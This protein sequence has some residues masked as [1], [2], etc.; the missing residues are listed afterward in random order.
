MPKLKYKVETPY[1]ET[2]RSAKVAGMF[3][4]S[5]QKKLIKEWEFDFPIETVKKDWNIGLIVGISG[6]G[7]SILAKKIFGEKNYHSGFEW[8]NSKSFLDSF[9]ES[10]GIK[11]ITDALSHIGFSSPP[12]WLLPFEKLSTGQKFRAEMARCLFEY[13][14]LFVFDEFTSVVDRNVAKTGSVAIQKYIRALNR[15]VVLVSCHYDIMEWLQPD[16]CFDFST[17]SL[18]T[19]YLQRPQIRLEIFKCNRSLWKLFKDHHYLSTDISPFAQCFVGLINKVPVAFASY[20]HFQH[21]IVKNTKREHRTVVLPDYQGL[22]FGNIL[23][24]FVADYCITKG[25]KYFS[26]TSHPAMIFSR[27]KSPNWV[28][29]RKPSMVRDQ[30]KNYKFAEAN[31]GGRITASFRYVGAS[32]KPSLPEQ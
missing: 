29:I 8:D 30:N 7:K 5:P 25:F 9:P 18:N 6:A 23:S 4:I 1:V 27:I 2:F 21:P 17:K 10:I 16:W 19:V 3:D 32:N 20:L 11:D 15:K 13:C 28:M 31:S 12:S 24:N 14:D 22:G 26:I